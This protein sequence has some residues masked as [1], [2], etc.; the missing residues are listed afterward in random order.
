MITVCSGYAVKR[1]NA[2]VNDVLGNIQIIKGVVCGGIQKS[3][4]DIHRIGE[5]R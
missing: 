2:L 5:Y 3:E 4:P 1:G